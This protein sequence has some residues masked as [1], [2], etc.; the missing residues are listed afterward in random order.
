MTQENTLNSRNIIYV[1]QEYKQGRVD[2]DVYVNLLQTTELSDANKIAVLEKAIAA[3]NC[4]INNQRLLRGRVPRN[5]E[6][7]LYVPY[8][9]TV[10]NMDLG[11][12]S[13]AQ[14][15][16]VITRWE[17]ERVAWKDY[18]QQRRLAR[19]NAINSSTSSS[20]VGGIDLSEMELNIQGRISLSDVPEVNK[21]SFNG[22]GLIKVEYIPIK[23]PQELFLN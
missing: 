16:Q 3:Y 11:N 22:F 18:F 23:N 2:R 15:A 4:G 8:V 20:S 1:E 14:A 19:T 7:N 5:G 21:L 17:D 9:M 10:M 13:Q 6:T 12:I